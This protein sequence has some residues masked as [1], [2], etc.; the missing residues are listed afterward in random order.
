MKHLP[1]FGES[2]A[3][4]FELTKDDDHRKMQLMIMATIA[5]KS[6]GKSPGTLPHEWERNKLDYVLVVFVAYGSLGMSCWAGHRIA[7]TNTFFS[8]YRDNGSFP[9]DIEIDK[10][11]APSGTFV[12]E[13]SVDGAGRVH[14]KH[15]QDNWAL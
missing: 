1:L 7:L 3:I 4:R 9:L 11:K 12:S 15:H 6:L 5:S 10:G 8:T 14:P 13:H 2:N